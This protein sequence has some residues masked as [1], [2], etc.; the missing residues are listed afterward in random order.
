VSDFD[1][2]PFLGQVSHWP[3]FIDKDTSP[4]QVMIFEMAPGHAINAL[5][6]LIRW[7]REQWSEQEIRRT[8]LAMALLNQAVGASV[9]YE[10]DQVEVPHIDDIVL[11]GERLLNV[12]DA[13]DIITKMKDVHPSLDALH[14]VKI[15]VAL[16]H[17]YDAQFQP[18]T[19][20]KEST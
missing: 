17:A 1:Y 19:T 16:H 11:A 2:T 7:A 12:E 6:K 5:H 15:A 8:P 4:D 14:P 3:H 13:Y 18:T 20:S 9:L 10:V